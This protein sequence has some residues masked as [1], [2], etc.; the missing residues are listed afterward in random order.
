MCLPTGVFFVFCFF[1]LK[2]NVAV[3]GWHALSTLQ[4]SGALRSAAVQSLKV[5]SA[6]LQQLITLNTFAFVNGTCLRD[7]GGE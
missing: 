2:A 1:S 6:P 4:Q 3:C 7:S 5:P